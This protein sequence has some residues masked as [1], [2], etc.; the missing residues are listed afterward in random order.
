MGLSKKQK[1]A[2]RWMVLAGFGLLAVGAVLDLMWLAR[3][4]SWIVYV[5][6]LLPGMQ[7]LAAWRLRVQYPE[8]RTGL[9]R[10]GVPLTVIALVFA[11]FINVVVDYATSFIVNLDAY[12]QVVAEYHDPQLVAHFPEEIPDEASG[13]VFFAVSGF[14]RRERVVQLRIGLPPGQIAALLEEYQVQAV[15]VFQGGDS[16]EHAMLPEGAPTTY[17]YTSQTERDAFPDSYEILVLDAQAEKVNAEG[18]WTHGYSY[19]VAID[20][21]G[22]EIVYWLDEW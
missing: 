7:L 16:N 6:N 20:L 8:R 21:E 3:Q 22:A 2:Y 9:A 4:P 10:F 13:R 5:I 17:F 14:L 18:F 1:Q 12:P 19:G 15:Y 11:V